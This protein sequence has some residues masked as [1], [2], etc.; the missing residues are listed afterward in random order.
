MKGVKGFSKYW[1]RHNFQHENNSFKDFYYETIKAIKRFKVKFFNETYLCGIIEYSQNLRL[2][3]ENIIVFRFQ[4]LL[5]YY[6]YVL[7]N[8]FFFCKKWRFENIWER[9]K[10]ISIFPQKMES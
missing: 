4:A 10:Y 5:E 8:D 2:N 3:L 1:C 7:W 6:V 9:K